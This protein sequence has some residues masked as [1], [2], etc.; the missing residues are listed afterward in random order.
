MDF[1]DNDNYENL[2]KIKQLNNKIQIVLTDIKDYEAKKKNNMYFLKIQTNT[3]QSIYEKKNILLKKYYTKIIKNIITIYNH[4]KN[5]RDYKILI[6]SN[7]KI[8]TNNSI[9]LIISKINC[10]KIYKNSLN[11]SKFVKL[12]NKQL[13]ISLDYFN[14]FSLY[15]LSDNKLLDN[16]S[17]SLQDIK[18]KTYNFYLYIFNYSFKLRDC[19]TNRINQF[20]YITKYNFNLKNIHLELKEYF[21]IKQPVDKQINKLFTI[22]IKLNKQIEKNTKQNDLL[23]K[24]TEDIKNKYLCLQK[25]LLNQEKK[26]LNTTFNFVKNIHELSIRIELSQKLLNSYKI[27]IE[28]V[29]NLLKEYDIIKGNKLNN[30]QQCMICLEDIEYG[31]TTECKHNFHYSCINLYVF[32]IISRINN[33]EI[34]C[35]LC[36][37]FI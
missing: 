33:I 25:Y 27:E 8:I 24:R 18:F 10:D 34:K 21:K 14:K 32:N 13:D 9:D 22:N 7:D 20:Q 29:E 3:F 6:K 12:L 11:N 37:Q 19:Y 30:H 23:Y 2:L 4:E 26:N 36:R 17:L 35:P 31:I 1:F 16:L 5:N 28:N 15:Y